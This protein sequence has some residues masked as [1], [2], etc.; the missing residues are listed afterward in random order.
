MVVE[1]RQITPLHF[2]GRKI[3]DIINPWDGFLHIQLFK[4][5]FDEGLNKVKE[6]SYSI[7]GVRQNVKAGGVVQ[8]APGESITLECWY[9]K[10]WVEGWV[11]AGEVSLV[12]DDNGDN[13]L[14]EAPGR[15]PTSQEDVISHH[16]LCTDY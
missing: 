16:L 13:H 10:F 4:A 7:D 5:T 3:E 9:H 1:D 15:L 6:V 2:H 12:N 8:F 11:L 14:H